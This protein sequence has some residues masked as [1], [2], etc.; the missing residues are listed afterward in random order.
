MRTLISLSL[1]LS[2]VSGNVAVAAPLAH[3]DVKAADALRA[4]K[5]SLVDLIIDTEE[6][7]LDV[8]FGQQ[9]IPLLIVRINTTLAA[10]ETNDMRL[11][12]VRDTFR[13]LEKSYAF[14]LKVY[15]DGLARYCSDRTFADKA[16][17]VFDHAGGSLEKAARKLDFS[18]EFARPLSTQR[19]CPESPDGL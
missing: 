3:A 14:V 9:A 12:R 4:A 17:D 6:R 15:D 19:V 11:P 10:L 8:L 16:G 1:I 5:K 18:F 2:L 13:K 7:E